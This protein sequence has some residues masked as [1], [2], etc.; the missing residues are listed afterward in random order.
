MLIFCASSHQLASE[1]LLS[2]DR[3]LLI[4]VY[5]VM[6]SEHGFPNAAATVYDGSNDDDDEKLRCLR[7]G[8][9]IS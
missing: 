7:R 3:R 8:R 1:V 2:L 9:G 5:T 4:V 6:R